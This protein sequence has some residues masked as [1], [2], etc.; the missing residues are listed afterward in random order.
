MRNPVQTTRPV[1]TIDFKYAC[2]I[3]FIIKMKSCHIST[4]KPVGVL[5]FGI[6]LKI[7]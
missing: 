5:E 7:D 3:L 6:Y 1:E 2:N 4:K